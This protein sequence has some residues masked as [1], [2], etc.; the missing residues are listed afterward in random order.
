MQRPEGT[1]IPPWYTI[2]P[3]GDWRLKTLRSLFGRGPSSP[4]TVV[5]VLVITLLLEGSITYTMTAG[6]L[7]DSALGLYN[8]QVGW[9]VV[10]VAMILAL[11]ALWLAGKDRQLSLAITVGAGLLTL[12]LLGSTVGLINVLFAGS[13]GAGEVVMADVIFIAVTNVL[14]FSIWYW[15]IDPPGIDE[16]QPADARWE[17]LFPQRAGAL[18]HYEDWLPSYTDYLFL[19]FSTSLAFS[20]T[21]TLPLTKRSKLLMML[22]AGVSVVTIVF[23]ASS[24]INSL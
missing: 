15:I 21:D 2:Q 1:R 20:P 12:G 16:S 5:I 13:T 24:A 4:T 23:I 18:P 19:A 6:R 14:V 11:V 3:R 9:T 10:R 17:F 22:Q 7:A 8:L